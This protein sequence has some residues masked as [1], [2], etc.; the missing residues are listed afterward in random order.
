MKSAKSFFALGVLVT[1]NLTVQFLFQW[2]VIV[3]LGS[4]ERSDV[5]FWHHGTSPVYFNGT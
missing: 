3:T 4:G 1:I 2:V 5:F